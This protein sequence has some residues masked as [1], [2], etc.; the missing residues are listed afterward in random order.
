MAAQDSKTEFDAFVRA[1]QE[2]AQPDIDWN[3]QRDE[4]LV[5]LDRLYNE[6]HSLLSSYT[7]SGQIQLQYQKVELNEEE[8]GTYQA[9]RLIIKIG[10][11]EI[12]LEP[13]GTL[14][15][16]T[17]GRVDV[18]GPAGKTRF[19]LVDKD[20]TRPRIKVTVQAGPRRPPAP[21]PQQKV[22]EWTWKIV[23][24]PPTIQ[25]IELTR[26]SLFRAIMEVAGG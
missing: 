8:I 1:Q 4:W 9:R 22:P 3:R 14:L 21:E 7:Q 16:G 25:Y 12:V 13:I 19:I 2:S 5:Y 17:K 24:P 15:I 18:T 11:K 10:G 23:T 6:I 20:A 26:E